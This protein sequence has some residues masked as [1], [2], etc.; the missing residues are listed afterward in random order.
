MGTTTFALLLL[1]SGT[2][3]AAENA[4]LPESPSAAFSA[5]PGLRSTGTYDHK[6]ASRIPTSAEGR[7]LDRKFL[8][9]AAVSTAAIFADSYT[10]T[11]I[12]ENYRARGLGPCTVEGGEPAL[13]GLHP[14]TARSYEVAASMSGGAVGVSYLA[15]KYLPGKIRWLWPSAFIY[16]T[17]VSVH[18]FATNL[19]RC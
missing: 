4:S 6:G 19:S 5:A 10:T 3:F 2:C 18:G 11:W 14:T 13:Y 9:F 12:G 8:T 16:E 15:K 1:A 7:I 17:G